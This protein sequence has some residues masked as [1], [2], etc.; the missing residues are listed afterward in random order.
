[1]KIMAEQRE[2]QGQA[3]LVVDVAE[4]SQVFSVDDAGACTRQRRCPLPVVSSSL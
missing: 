1:M 2:L 3:S 4:S